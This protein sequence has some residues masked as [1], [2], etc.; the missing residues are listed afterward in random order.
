MPGPD[1]TS[2]L[3]VDL[4]VGRVLLRTYAWIALTRHVPLGAVVALVGAVCL[5]AYG[6]EDALVLTAC[7]C[8]ALN[9]KGPLRT[10]AV[11]AGGYWDVT[12]GGRPARRRTPG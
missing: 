5:D 8:V 3:T 12:A 4:T 7:W 9:G 1:Q 2:S 6:A 11:A 10:A